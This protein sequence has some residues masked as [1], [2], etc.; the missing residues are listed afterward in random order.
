MSRMI[1][2]TEP[3]KTL[4]I[5]LLAA[6]QRAVDNGHSIASWCRAAQ[7]ARSTYYRWLSGKDAP[8]LGAVARLIAAADEAVR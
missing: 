6:R 4:W 2:Q 1:F 7:V 5:Q 8:S 3:H